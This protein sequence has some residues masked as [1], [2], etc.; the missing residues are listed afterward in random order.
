MKPKVFVGSSVEGLSIGYA[1]Q[2]NLRRTAEVTLW[3]QGVFQLSN[4][5]LE[6][7]LAG[8]TSFDFAIFVFSPDDL[9]KIRGAEESAVRDNVV[10]EL[11][12]FVGRLGKE[13]CFIFV[14]ENAQLHIP[15]DLI[16]MTPA[17]YE[18]DRRDGNEQAGCGS[19]CH[20]VAERIR[21]G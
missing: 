1:V 20:D 8:L 7:L 12:L 2:K 4:S 5:T 18:V 6:S 15:T 21:G 19:A 13:R 3:D 17:T 9:L 14:P 11:G 16:G 10:F